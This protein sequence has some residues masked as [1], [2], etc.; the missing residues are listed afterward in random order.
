[1]SCLDT[2]VG[3]AARAIPVPLQSLRH[4][5]DTNKQRLYE[6]II[7]LEL[8]EPKS[9]LTLTCRPEALVVPGAV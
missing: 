2:S 7:E 9:G 5:D 4:L 6:Q 1:M 8:T 3:P